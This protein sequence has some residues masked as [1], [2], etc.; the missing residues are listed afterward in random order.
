MKKT[1][2]L[3]LVFC[4]LCGSVSVLA[5][6]AATEYAYSVETVS[7]EI[8]IP[9]S[10]TTG[11]WKE[12]GAVKNYDGGQHIYSGNK[13]DTAT[14]LIQDIKAGNYRVFY[15]LMPHV[16]ECKKFTVDISHNG[17]VS[18][19]ELSAKL[20][21]G[22]T[23]GPGWVDCGV[24]DFAGSG[25]EKASTTHPGGIMRAGAIKLVPTN[26]AV[27][28]VPAA[29]EKEDEKIEPPVIEETKPALSEGLTTEIFANETVIP[30]T[31]TTGEWKK[32]SAV[33][34]YD[35]N[36]H[37]YSEGE[38]KTM[39]FKV[40]SVKEGNYEVYFW[41]MAHTKN[42]SN[43]D[44]TVKHNGK[45]DALTLKQR[46]GTNTEAGWSLMGV[47]DFKG[48]G[49]ESVIL[50]NNVGIV[51]GS[52]IKIVPTEKAAGEVQEVVKTEDV[53]VDPRTPVKP[54]VADG[55]REDSLKQIAGAP[56]D[57][58]TLLFADEFDAPIDQDIWH[59]RLDEKSGGK[60][61][62]ANVYTHDGRM[63][64]DIEYKNIN[65]TE[66]I[67]G[68]GIISNKLFGYGYYE[69]KGSMMNVTGGVHSAFWLHGGSASE[70]TKDFRKIHTQE[71]DFEF[72]SDRPYVACNYY[73][74]IGAKLGFYNQIME[75]F[76]TSVEHIYAFEWLP[77]RLNFYV[78]GELVWS[79]DGEEAQLHYAQQ[80]LWITSLAWETGDTKADK[81]L[82]PQVNS[83]DYV[84]YYAMPLKDINLLGASEF[85]YNQ[86]PEFGT[87]PV[88]LQ[89][90]LAWGETGSI[91]ASLLERNDEYAVGGNHVLAHRS[92]EDYKV[93]T[94]QRL[95]HIPNAT[96]NFEA[97]VM[98]SGDQNESKVV[99]SGFDGDRTMEV[100]IPQTDKMTKIELP[101]VVVK[102]NHV[103][104]E[105]ISDAK[106]GQWMLMD[107]PSFYATSGEVVEKH[108][109]YTTKFKNVS[110]G[111]MYVQT[112]HDAG[113]TSEG[114]WNNSS[115]AGYLNSKT[116]YSYEEDGPAS[117]SF[118]IEVPADGTYHIRFF[119]L[120]HDNTGKN[121]H[122]YY[123]VNG[124]KKGETGIDL[125][126]GDAG[127]MIL[128]EEALKAGD[129]VTV[130]IDKEYGG[131][132]RASAAAISSVDMLNIEEVLIL[133][134]NDRYVWTFGEKLSVDANNP[135]V[136]PKT[137]NDR[138]MVP[139]RFIAESLGATVSYIDATEEIVIELSGNK[140]V[141]KVN[142]DKMYVNGNEVQLDAPAY[143]EN[144]RTLVPVRA[145]SEGLGKVVTWV[146]DRFVIIGDKAYA[147]DEAMFKQIEKF[148]RQ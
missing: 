130:T 108:I 17:K 54:Y 65:G 8:I 71:I 36:G 140:V 90:P 119:K 9:V 145:I 24:F 14:Y 89:T 143:V 70:Y 81:A 96:Y 113:F 117:A 105:I 126:T 38:G 12:S 69:F 142:S 134:L 120:I 20:A 123:S 116:C 47:Y 35:G 133:E 103:K 15:W 80:F 135:D 19:V 27:S 98:S 5:A 43:I 110:L 28:D 3:L 92:E 106:A 84:R 1:I 26:D 21:E 18:A 60:N 125:T 72:N 102:D 49:N 93:T 48:D 11:E 56:N 41:V 78:D 25:A 32:S 122:V 76:D 6:S 53:P 137:V 63:Y 144:D 114:K 97:Y 40:P 115:L 42:I 13:G 138:T 139:V 58:Y 59:Y 99:I 55:A 22:E 2:C 132:L 67:T 52:A 111:E 79:K 37:I 10:E 31:E 39:T 4:M 46:Y 95:Y 33:P 83:F 45:T 107:N 44:L 100:A 88:A 64:H 75:G 127:W 121:C 146:P 94:Y 87:T 50:T 147:S 51:R 61:L 74:P 104:I 85:E 124:E 118:E 109:P 128:G 131:L 73:C 29:P 91:D 7:G 68:G 129:K 148:D 30:Y 101:G 57:K 77:N 112:I 66:T 16:K 62:A 86:N 141:L 82:L 34:G 23:A 136:R